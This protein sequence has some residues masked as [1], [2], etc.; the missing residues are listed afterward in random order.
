MASSHNTCNGVIAAAASD[1]EDAASSALAGDDAVSDE[2]AYQ[3]FACM[4][5]DELPNLQEIHAGKLF[6][7]R[8]WSANRAFL[9]TIRASSAAALR[10]KHNLVHDPD[11]WR[12][13][14][15]PFTNADKLSRM[16]A[17]ERVRAELLDYTDTAQI[18]A[19]EYVEDVLVLTKTQFVA[20][21]GFWEKW[22]EAKANEKFE[23]LL[24][25]QKSAHA[26]AGVPR[27]AY[28]GIVKLRSRTCLETRDGVREEREA[29]E[30][31]YELK[32][33]R[34][35]K[36]T[37]LVPGTAWVTTSP[38]KPAS[39]PRAASSVSYDRLKAPLGDGKQNE[40]RTQTE[41]EATKK[42][43]ALRQTAL[44]LLSPKERMQ[45]QEL[46]L[47]ACDA[48]LAT[49]IGSRGVLTSLEKLFD[50]LDDHVNES[51][52]CKDTACFIESLR[53]GHEEL[54]ALRA[55]AEYCKIE[56]MVKLDDGLKST[57]QHLDTVRK[58]SGG[59]HGRLEVQKRQG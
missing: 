2:A 35:T 25:E 24:V 4:E 30:C 42:A 31:N 13:A 7:R 40:D 55:R 16:E 50:S 43:E 18:K 33:R 27:V 3:C 37:Q 9:R 5:T 52:I 21:V 36:K 11:A 41:A 8:C 23:R 28:P 59:A 6:H 45:R 46:L 51:E 47:V 53:R 15:M 20:H 32:R 58:K 14:V 48:A 34:L 10:H 12:A 22:S 26:E 39:H 17:R 56:D 54:K 44:G 19:T 1:A 49:V 29:S 57:Q 38:S